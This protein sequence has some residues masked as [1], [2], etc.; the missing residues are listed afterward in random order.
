M[1]RT[2]PGADRPFLRAVAAVLFLAVCAYIGVGLFKGLDPGRA[3]AR[4]KAVSL[5][6][7][8]ELEGIAVRRELLISGSPGALSLPEEGSRVPAGTLAPASALFFAATDGLER[9]APEGLEELTVPAL[10][11]LLQAE[12]ARE[13][14]TLGR[15]VQGYDWFYAAL[16]PADAEL[17]KAGELTL[18][19][20]GLERRVKARLV[21]VSE[22]EAG[23]R[24]L[25]L[26]LT[27]T[28]GELLALRKTGARLILAEYGGLELPEAAVH[29][30]ESG[31]TYVNTLAAAGPEPVPV[32]ILYR[33][34]GRCVAAFSTGVEALR[35]GQT[36]LLG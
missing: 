4:V 14:D 28:D 21:S 27:E 36:V 2:E 9:L 19:F 3:T 34:E 29:T 23:K 10:A 20:D 26:R 16:S 31:R 8:V 1:R 30:D 5:S 11:E 15:L 22:A 17:P 18:V 24:A 35:E 7:S 6:R 13:A 32:E 12:P 25:L 33:E